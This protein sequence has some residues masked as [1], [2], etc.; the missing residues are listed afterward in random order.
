M[1]RGNRQ[2]TVFEETL[3]TEKCVSM[4]REPQEWGSDV[5]A[6]HAN[7]GILYFEMDKKYLIIFVF[8]FAISSLV[9]IVVSF[10]EWCLYSIVEIV[11]EGYGNANN[12]CQF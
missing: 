1:K 9:L 4:D 11:Y 2:V 3:K 7:K 6:L 8:S 5:R 10:V 12:S